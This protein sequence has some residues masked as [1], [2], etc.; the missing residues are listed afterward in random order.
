M[1]NQLFF[2]LHSAINK[3]SKK[4]K[5]KA[6]VLRDLCDCL[7][8]DCP[9]CHFP[10]P[11]C[12]SPKCGTFCRVG[13]KVQIERITCDGKPDLVVYSPFYYEVD[14]DEKDQNNNN[15]EKKS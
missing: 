5:D 1:R 13:R 11:K 15:A 9:G 14:E 7:E 6:A 4:K 2:L 10:C 8:M 3:E 12:S